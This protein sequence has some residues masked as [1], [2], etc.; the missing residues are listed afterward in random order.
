MT[1]GIGPSGPAGSA[2][3]YGEERGALPNKTLDLGA[4]TF[5]KLLV[6]QLRYQDPFSG[7]EDMGDFMG[8][9][10]QFTLL[11]KVVQMQKSLE[12]FT[13]AQEP[14]QALSLLNKIVEVW[15]DSGQVLRGEVTA[16]RL[17]DGKPLLT[18]QGKEFPWQAVLQVESPATGGE[19]SS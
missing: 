9:I 3:A 11:E 17:Q 6:T 15:E 1:T 18:V 14:F 5:L 12:E 13:A 2:G 16:V 10:A 4:D 19:E 8:Q 7:G